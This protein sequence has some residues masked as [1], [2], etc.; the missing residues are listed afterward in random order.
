[1]NENKNLDFFA[2]NE[3]V[4]SKRICKILLWMTLVFPALFVCSA[5]GIF[6]IT[7]SDLIPITAIGMI[8]TISPTILQ[9]VGVNNVFIKNYSIITMALTIAIMATNIHIG[10]YLTYPLAVA[11]SCMYFDKKF[12]QRSAIIGFICM[13]VAMFFRSA[14]ADLSNGDSRMRWF[15]AYTLGYTIE[16]IAMSSVFIGISKQARTLLEKLNTTENIQEVLSNC[17]NASVSLSGV[18]EKLNQTIKKTLNNNT[19]IEGEADKTIESCRDNLEHVKLTSDSIENMGSVMQQIR[20][21]ADE[22]RVISEESYSTTENYIKVMDDAVQSIHDIGNSSDV[23]KDRI[24]IVKE[25]TGQISEFA[26]TINSIAAQTNILALNASI[27]AARAGEQGK[28][29]AVVAAEV[30]KL[31]SEC[32]SATQSIT[33]QVGEMHEN[34]EAAMN[35][36]VQNQT[37][38]KSGIDEITKARDEAKKILDLQ[39]QSTAKVKEVEDNLANGLEHQRTVMEMAENMDAVTNRSL[40]QAQTIQDAIKEQTVMEEE[41]ETAFKEVQQISDRLLEISKSGNH[42]E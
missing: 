21:R 31:A 41:M 22:M 19:Q 8:C 4:V 18:L 30:G 20:V 23:I 35:S 40:E 39:D 26:R 42:E 34:V 28:G 7:F 36:V 24:E 17:E 12:T 10:I 6:R 9:K 25:C 37:S 3:L 32:Q 11:L 27:E 13:V 1:M 15:I 16:Y 2:R 5:I 33:A 38:V 14:G 29:F